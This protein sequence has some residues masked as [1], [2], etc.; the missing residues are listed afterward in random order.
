MNAFVHGENTKTRMGTVY[1]TM[2]VKKVR[3]GTNNQISL[4]VSSPG[5]L[6][7]FIERGELMQRRRSRTYNRSRYWLPIAV[8]PFGY[9]HAGSVGVWF[10]VKYSKKIKEKNIPRHIPNPWRR[11]NFHRTLQW[12]QWYE[13]YSSISVTCTPP[14]E[15]TDCAS[16]CPFTCATNEHICDYGCDPDNSCVCPQGMVLFTKNNGTCIKKEDC[17]SEEMTDTG[18]Q[19]ELMESD[20]TDRVIFYGRVWRRI[21]PCRLRPSMSRNVFGRWQFVWFYNYEMLERRPLHM[22]TKNDSTG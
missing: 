5:T 17:P 8:D 3:N 21:S 19:A 4:S 22:S 6:Y 10:C 15:Y 14:M 20:Y 13:L 18:F 11:Y 1:G 12:R 7:K 16:K 9:Y 2:S